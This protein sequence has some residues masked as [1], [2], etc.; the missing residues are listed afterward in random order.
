[1]IKIRSIF[2]LLCV[3]SSILAD[4]SGLAHGKSKKFDVKPVSEDK[5]KV[6]LSIMKYIINFFYFRS[7]YKH[8]DM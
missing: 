5:A 7:I 6:S 2:I 1:M 8:S 4:T 3:A